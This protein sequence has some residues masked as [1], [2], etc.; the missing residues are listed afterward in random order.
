MEFGKNSIIGAALIVVAI[1]LAIV[2]NSV[3]GR[4]MELNDAECGCGANEIGE[5]CPH[6]ENTLPIEIYFGYTTSAVLVIIGAY[7]IFSDI[8]SAKLKSESVKNWGKVTSAL[9]GEEK[10]LYEIIAGADGVM[11]QSELVEKSGLAKVKVSRVLDRL[12][13]RNLLERRRRGMSNVII[14]KRP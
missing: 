6:S 3:G 13:A 4:I 8:R 12:E 5:F 2:I 11:F 7:L 9:H 10:A 1:I 14:L